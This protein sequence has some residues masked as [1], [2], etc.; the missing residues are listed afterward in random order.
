MVSASR[1]LGAV[2]TA[3]NLSFLINFRYD[4]VAGLGGAI[5]VVYF[6]VGERQWRTK[7]AQSNVLE[8]NKPIDKGTT[9]SNVLAI[10]FMTTS[11]NVALWIRGRRLGGTPALDASMLSMDCLALPWP[12][13]CCVAAL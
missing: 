4:V 1:V 10:L 7:A 12:A 2:A 8:P 11:S 13:L 3:A 9:L 5:S 6:A